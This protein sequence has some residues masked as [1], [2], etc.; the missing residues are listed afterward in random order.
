MRENGFLKVASKLLSLGMPAA[1]V[2]FFTMICFGPW[3]ISDKE[4]FAVEFPYTNQFSENPTTKDPTNFIGL[5]VV[6]VT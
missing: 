1:S 3:S 2:A 6:N 4:C 5:H